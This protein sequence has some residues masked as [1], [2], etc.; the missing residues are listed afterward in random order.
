L[1]LVDDFRTQ[2]PPTEQ[3]AI[4][5]SASVYVRSID[6]F[7]RVRT[8]HPCPV[9]TYA[10]SEAFESRASF[11]LDLLQTGHTG[12][13]C[14]AST[15]TH[16]QTALSYG[17]RPVINGECSY[18]G[19][20]DSNWQDIQRFLFWSHLLSGAAGHT[21]GTMAIS[22]F[23]AKD[24]PYMPMSHVSMHFWE[25]AI[26]WLGAAHV[27]VGRRILESLDWSTLEPRQEMVTPN[28][29]PSDW[30]L[31]YS[32]VTADGTIVTYLPGMGLL[33]PDGWPA[34]WPASLA[35]L[36]F[37]GLRESSY[38]ATFIDPRTGRDDLSFT[39]VP[40][41]GAATIEKVGA[42]YHASPTGEDWVLVLRPHGR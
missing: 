2:A 42:A 12:A 4:W 7:E 19:I 8:V 38:Q 22:T 10:S 41:E 29:G 40:A 34:D 17:D 11:D 26:D 15:M 33:S 35:K 28:A 3:V 18:E 27:G 24:D 20:F 23:N 30:F 5:E 32:A 31:P 25:D 36:G 16:L 6:P 13:N 39:V 9:F 14:V 21:Y 37:T 1:S